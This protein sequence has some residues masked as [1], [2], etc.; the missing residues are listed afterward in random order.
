MPIIAS[1][2]SRPCHMPRHT[3]TSPITM[4]ML[5]MKYEGLDVFSVMDIS[6]AK[7]PCGGLFASRVEMLRVEP[8]SETYQSETFYKRSYVGSCGMA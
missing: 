4:L 3:S 6:I 5:R 8:R 1:S 7:S 2:M